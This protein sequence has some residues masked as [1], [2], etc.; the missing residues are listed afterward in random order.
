MPVWVSLHCKYAELTSNSKILSTHWQW[1]NTHLRIKFIWFPCWWPWC[2]VPGGGIVSQWNFGMDG[3]GRRR[4]NGA[5]ARRTVRLCFV[6]SWRISVICSCSACVWITTFIF[7]IS[8]Q[9]Q[10]CPVRFVNFSFNQLSFFSHSSAHWKN[11]FFVHANYTK[12]M[13]RQLTFIL[14]NTQQ[15]SK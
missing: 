4:T 2:Y 1:E 13:Q 11:A 15:N 10:N 9:S 12:L 6:W 7:I 3:Y 5:R 8:L 14:F